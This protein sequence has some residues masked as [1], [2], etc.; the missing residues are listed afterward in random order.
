MC[1]QFYFLDHILLLMLRRFAGRLSVIAPW[2]ICIWMWMPALRKLTQREIIFVRN[3]PFT[4]LSFATTLQLELL[5][6]YTCPFAYYN[7]KKK[8]FIQMEFLCLL[9]VACIMS[10]WRTTILYLLYNTISY[11]HMACAPTS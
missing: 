6:K 3:Y 7:N 10:R 11:V 2:A 5:N 1:T 9:M 4:Y 8:L